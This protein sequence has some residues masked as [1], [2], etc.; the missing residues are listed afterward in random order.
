MCMYFHVALVHPS[1]THVTLQ[2][3]LDPTANECLNIPAAETKAPDAASSS[4]KPKK[5]AKKAKTCHEAEETPLQDLNTK[6]NKSVA[7]QKRMRNV[8]C[9]RMESHLYKLFAHVQ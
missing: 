6:F 2:V 8:K 3:M 1:L 4:S 7:G 9:K 5:A